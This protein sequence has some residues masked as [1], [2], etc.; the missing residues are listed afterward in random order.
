MFFKSLTKST[1]IVLALLHCF[2]AI[3]VAGAANESRSVLASLSEPQRTAVLEGAGFERSSDWVDAIG[4][5]EKATKKWPDCKPLKY[6]LRRSK[7]HYGIERRYEDH[8]FDEAMLSMSR[9]E[10][11]DLYDEIYNQIR[12]NYLSPISYTNYVAHG[13]E[14]LYLA[15]ANQK[16]V[17][18]NLGNADASRV[19]ELRDVLRKAYWNKPISDRSHARVVITQVSDMAQRMLGISSTTVVMEYVF[20]G[21]NALDDYSSFLTP[22][23]LADLYGNIDGEFVGLGIEM[24]AVKGK[25]MLLVNVLPGS[26]ASEGGI[27]PGDHIIEI[28]G[29]DC[30]NMSTSEAAKLL[31]GKRNSR[32]RLSLQSPDTDEP[33]T[34][35][36]TRR[37]VE[38]KSI[39]VAKIVDPAAGIGYIKMTNFQ[40]NT[41]QELDQALA[42][43][44]RQGMRGLIW[45]VR[46]NPGGLLN[47]AAEVLDRFIDR[48][49]LVETRGRKNTPLPNNTKYSAYRVG[50]T[51]VPLV[52][53]VDGDS[54]SASEIVAGAIQDHK[55]GKVIGRTTYG[56]WSVQTVLMVREKFGMRLTTA[57]FYSPRGRNLHKIGLNPDLPVKPKQATEHTTFYRGSVDGVDVN[58]DPDLKAAIEVFQRSFALR[59]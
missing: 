16:F 24:K 35:N 2:I 3:G 30:R 26:P 32:V 21:C 11:L 37:E 17:A 54:A 42:K 43:L 44:N 49:T 28:G 46:G 48:G 39:P 38:V 4:H 53:L 20:G 23:R 18:R 33:W 29:Q 45:D 34:R 52:L 13:T 50:T 41:A 59:Q 36:F 5:Y 19:K 15:L 58:G 47:T 55:R 1:A 9:Y 7:I 14:S 51:R 8:S 22:D 27:L 10:A 57:K 12:S 40:T 31:R 56:K 6:G 25:G